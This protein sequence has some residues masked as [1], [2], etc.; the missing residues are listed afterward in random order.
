MQQRYEPWFRL[1][2]VKNVLN[3]EVILIRSFLPTYLSH[4]PLRQDGFLIFPPHS[5]TPASFAHSLQSRLFWMGWNRLISLCACTMQANEREGDRECNGREG[6]WESHIPFL[7]LLWW[8]IKASPPFAPVQASQ[9]GSRTSNELGSTHGWS[10]QSP[11][12]SHIQHK[13]ITETERGLN[14]GAKRIQKG[15]I[16]KKCHTPVKCSP[17][18]QLADKVSA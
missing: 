6:N 4:L 10:C 9:R 7:F 16:K 17:R 18:L 14:T 3:T 5:C 12:H 15:K 2:G 1:S 13:A 11:P 8:S